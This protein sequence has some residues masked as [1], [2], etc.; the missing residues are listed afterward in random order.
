MQWT[1]SDFAC[2][3]KACLGFWSTLAKE[4]QHV[5][6]LRNLFMGRCKQCLFPPHKISVTNQ[7]TLPSE[8]S[9][10]NKWVYWVYLQSKDEELLMRM[11]VT[12][13]QPHWKDSPRM[14]DGWPWVII[15]LT[16]PSLYNPSTYMEAPRSCVHSYG[17]I[18]CKI[19]KVLAGISG[20]GSMTLSTP[21][22]CE[23]MSTTNK[24]E[25]GYL[26]APVSRQQVIQSR[27][28]L[29]CTEDLILQLLKYMDRW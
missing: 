15:L 21:F 11:L 22:F 1:A 13:K 12:L 6:L 9:L 27:W 2:E 24:P 26:Q 5:G 25:R 14:D 7:S 18:A 4:A 19:L 10:G 29:G 16:F 20:E 23:G 8:L 17:R 28:C 3:N